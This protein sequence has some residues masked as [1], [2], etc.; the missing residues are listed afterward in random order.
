MK[1][2]AAA[3]H[4]IQLVSAWSSETAEGQELGS[5]EMDKSIEDWTM[6]FQGYISDALRGRA[7]VDCNHPVFRRPTDV[8]MDTVKAIGDVL[9]SRGR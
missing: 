5:I 9:G 4:F 8:A 7:D 2:E 6:D 3:M 1:V